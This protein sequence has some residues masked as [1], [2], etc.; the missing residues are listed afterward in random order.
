MVLEPICSSSLA[1][2]ESIDDKCHVVTWPL[3]DIDP[4]Q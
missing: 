2:G 1:D 4:I 3:M